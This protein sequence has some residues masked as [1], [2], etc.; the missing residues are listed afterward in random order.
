MQ[1]SLFRVVFKFVLCASLLYIPSVGLAEEPAATG[2]LAAPI[3]E[4]MLFEMPSVVTASKKA[5]SIDKAPGVIT[6]ITAEEIKKFGGLTLYDVLQRAPSI[7]PVGSHLFRNNAMIVRGDLVSHYDNHILV[8]INGRPFRDDI[9]GGQNATLYEIFPVEVIERIEIIRGPGS[10]LYGTNAMDGVINIITRQPAKEL[11]ADLTAGAG[12]Y[13]AMI[14]RGTIG[15]KTQ[16]FNLLATANYFK[17]DGWDFQASTVLPRT[18]NTEGSM[19][20][21]N[22]DASGSLFLGYKNFTFNVYHAV[23]KDGNL[24]I[25]PAFQYSGGEG[26]SWLDL[27]RLF[28]DA[29]YSQQIF[30]EYTVNANVTL[31]HVRFAAHTKQV[32]AGEATSDLL[33]E[34]SVGGP[35]IDKINMV[36][37]GLLS[38]SQRAFSENPHFAEFNKNNLSG[39]AQVD[40]TPWDEFKLIAGAQYNKPSNVDGVTVPRLGAIYQWTDKLG[41]KVSYAE[42]FRAP[43]AMETAISFPG[44]IIGNPDLKP[45]IC[46]TADIHVFYNEKT[47]QSAVTFFR[48]RYENLIA[49][50]MSPSIPSTSTYDNVSSMDISGVEFETKIP[51]TPDILIEG[52]ACYQEEQSDLLLTP[53]TMVKVGVSYSTPFGLSLAVFDNHF[54]DPKKNAGQALNPEAKA[55]DLISLNIT[56]NPPMLKSAKLNLFI[57]NVL[58]QAYFFPEFDKNWVNTLPLEPGRAIFGTI[59]YE[60]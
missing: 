53:N 44:V 24:G 1:R 18:T 15:Y 16:D 43:W 47:V 10:V 27:S 57:Q 50:I 3:T 17:N 40:Y 54:G 11:E 42:A 9:A 45:E 8:L 46:K 55:I 25:N 5:E 29:G 58:N 31:N 12:S 56:Y 51:L 21:Y 2:E 28:A 14:G 32:P 35:I 52:S 20:Y 48:T 34:I 7:Q 26:Q 13:G 33:G 36:V 37:G 30:G 41:T 39:Y 4:L 23:L 6:V 59:S 49:R 22:R 19:K 38:N 60:F